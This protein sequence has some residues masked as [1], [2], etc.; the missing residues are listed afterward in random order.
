M[1]SSLPRHQRD[2][3][4]WTAWFRRKLPDAGGA[5]V[6]SLCGHSGKCGSQGPVRG[7]ALRGRHTVITYTECNSL[8]RTWDILHWAIWKT[9]KPRSWFTV[10]E[11]E[12]GILLGK[13]KKKKKFLLQNHK[14]KFCFPWKLGIVL[15]NLLHISYLLDDNWS[16]I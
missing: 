15:R 1:R 2:P 4:S 9:S 7:S 5:A 10:C 6:L 14:V 3:F 12:S 13:K 11:E 16:E 8:L